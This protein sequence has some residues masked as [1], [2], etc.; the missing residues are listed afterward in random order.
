MLR[1][2]RSIRFPYFKRAALCCALI[3]A[4]PAASLAGQE[5]KPKLSLQQQIEQ[6]DQEIVLLRAELA[7]NNGDVEGL[8]R[9]IREL[10]EMDLIP[11]YK[12][13]FELLKAFLKEQENKPKPSVSVEASF[14]LPDMNGTVVVLLPLSGEYSVVGETIL[15]GLTENWPLSKQPVVL[16][17]AIYDNLF[18]LWELVKLYS[19]DFIIGPLDRSRSLAWQALN[20][21]I[22]TLYLNQLDHFNQNEKGLSPSKMS[23]LPQLQAFIEKGGYN[24]L[25]VLKDRSEHSEKLEQK[26]QQ[27]WLK[28]NPYTSYE[29]IVVTDRVDQAVNTALNIQSSMSRH[30][31]LQ[32]TLQTRLEFEPRARQDIDV[33]IDFLSRGDAVQVKPLID[34]YHLNR[35]LNLWYPSVYPSRLELQ[36]HLGAWQQTYAF[37]P[38]YLT[39]MDD[40]DAEENVI[41]SKTGLFYALGELSAKI[42]NNFRI[43]EPEQIIEYS[44][45]GELISDS[46][47]E[48]Q[49]LPN[50]Y[51]LDDK[52][53]QPVPELPFR[54]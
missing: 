39:Q 38:P 53:L 27:A 46:Y 31:W 23:G 10:D 16:D 41:E 30:N 47:G 20:T 5:E 42:V 43:L 54:F 17:T 29:S 28:E 7:R 36:A 18:E 1:I 49:L 40:S 6:I 9:Y 19:P 15:S 45:L 24:H 21:N 51:W 33:V 8:K 50:V 14:H 2:D 13:R 4:A 22:P 26:F 25:L 3:L 35:T 11:G 44:P 32:K 34:F 52:Q 48:L 12:A 37:L